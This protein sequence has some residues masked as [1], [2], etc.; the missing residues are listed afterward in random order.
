[1]IW[2]SWLASCARSSSDLDCFQH[3]LL[4]VVQKLKLIKRKL[5]GVRTTGDTVTAGVWTPCSPSKKKRT[6]D[7]WFL[8]LLVDITLFAAYPWANLKLIFMLNI[9]VILMA[10]KHND[11][12]TYQF[13]CQYLLEFN[14]Q[15]LHFCLDVWSSELKIL[16]SW[17]CCLQTTCIG[18][19]I[20]IQGK[21][22]SC[23]VWMTWGYVL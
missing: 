13:S 14:I 18:Q 12:G 3:S 1:M 16:A 22:S 9:V 15:S 5:F 2:V 11:L 6:V 17:S 21:L 23:K 10:G 7:L 4:V 8:L 20:Q 19:V